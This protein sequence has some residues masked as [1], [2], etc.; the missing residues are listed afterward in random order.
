MAPIHETITTRL[1]CRV[2]FKIRILEPHLSRGG[3]SQIEP[4]SDSEMPGLVSDDSDDESADDTEVDGW[5]AK[6]PVSLA[7]ELPAHTVTA[8]AAMLPA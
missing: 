7:A 2:D 6:Q 3:L 1:D 8:V 5:R 4:D